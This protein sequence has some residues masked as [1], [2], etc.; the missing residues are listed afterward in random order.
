[1]C[2]HALLCGVVQCL[3]L[4]EL[5]ATPPRCVVF[6]WDPNLGYSSDGTRN[7]SEGN[8]LLASGDAAVASQAA[9]P[10][11]AAGRGEWGCAW[12]PLF[13]WGSV[14]GTGGM[15]LEGEGEAGT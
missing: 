14:W 2:L 5:R 12:P 9:N 13:G 8:C 6:V 7:G 1:M 11:G 15:P 10:G 4:C 3:G